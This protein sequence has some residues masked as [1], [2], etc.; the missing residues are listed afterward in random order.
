MGPEENAVITERF[1]QALDALKENGRI[2]GLKTITT[3]YDLNYWNMHTLK[4]NTSSGWLKP[5]LL[6]YL[7]KDFGV[8]AV[9]LLTGDGTMF[10]D[11]TTTAYCDKERKIKKIVGELNQ[12]LDNG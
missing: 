3:A 2:R 8:S 6:S 9:W 1:F 5:I 11:E 4:K 10:G 7:V 12:I